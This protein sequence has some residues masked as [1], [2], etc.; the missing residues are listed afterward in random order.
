MSFKEMEIKQEYRSFQDDI[1]GE[2]YFP[3]LKQA[4]KYQRA[5]GFFSSTALIEISKGISGLVKNNGKIE[6]IASPKLSAEDVK[7]IEQGIKEKE[8]LIEK[9]INEAIFEPENE[10]EERRLDLLINLIA[11][12]IL[13]IKIAVLEN[14]N[15]IGMYHEKMGL[16]YDL[17]DNVIAF[18]GSMNESTT[19]FSYNMENIDVY[20]SWEEGSEH[21]RVEKKKLNFNAMWNNYEPYMKV[22]DFPEA[23]RKKL[24]QYRKSNEIYM[25]M[26]H[27]L[28]HKSGG[29]RNYIEKDK[30]EPSLPAWFT[31]RDYQKM[32]VN[33]WHEHQ[34]VGIFDMATGTGKTLTG[35][36]AVVELYKNRKK[37]LAVFIVCPY[38]HLVAQW[39]EDIEKF[40]MKPIICHSASP[41]KRWD[42]RL[43]DECLELELGMRNY[44]C[45]IFTNA[46]YSSNKVQT[47]I[48]R[49]KSQAVLVVDEAH[50]F[51]AEHLS[52]CMDEKIPY[53]LAL[54]ATL[55]RH[56]D[57]L[58]TKKLF[59]YFGEKCI[60]YS[61][62]EAIENNMLV[63][64]YYY[65]ILVCLEEDELEQYL[66]LTKNIGKAIMSG[67]DKE[68]SDYAK[69]LL[70]KRAR[71]VAAARQKVEALLAELEHHKNESHMLVY[72]G[73]TT[74]KD[75][76]YDEM[77]PPEED[78]RQ[79]DIVMKRLGNDLNMKVAKFTSEENAEK[80]EKLK[81]EFDSG[82]NLQ[83]LIAI[84]CL[85]EGVNIPSIQK[86]FIL[87]SSTNPKEY[88]QRRGR[89][90]RICQGKT[91][92]DIYDFVMTPLPLDSIDRY[93]EEIIQM[94]KSLVK[95]EIERMRDFANLAENPSTADE[96]IYRLID[97][98]D[99]GYDEMEEEWYE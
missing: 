31:I 43:K 20:K 12:D 93:R 2:F 94:S 70:I 89:V 74:M 80:R 81:K 57:D 99:I 56:G 39:V 98:Y 76:D 10:Y 30:K 40:G 72:C 27:E 14:G 32:A 53:R 47:I 11:N 55:K 67:K 28:R 86:A 45:A 71:L 24:F 97:K 79:I 9:R 96:L 92:A 37:P 21:N 19:A 84:R 50:N 6:L 33:N 95:R 51:G 18:S 8:E 54:S 52:K 29:K 38:Q 62:K 15:R 16:I 91:H 13:E 78:K 3:L 83:T 58:G 65:P 46:T 22:M 48:D 66:E 42:N 17:E 85:D 49:V 36:S 59:D 82:E 25:N 23:S 69:M 60:E 7:A 4:K 73:A 63:K 34:F 5:V 68:L 44:L 1:V 35:L 64:Y 75:I 90:L 26:D 87:A 41:Q 77:N 88:I 61:L